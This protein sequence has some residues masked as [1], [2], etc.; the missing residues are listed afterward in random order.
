MRHNSD[1][2][3]AHWGRRI[4]IPLRIKVINP[5]AVLTVAIDPIYPPSSESDSEYGRE[6]CMVEQG[7]EL[8]EK[9]IEEIQREAAE[10][11][12][13]AKCLAREL[14]KKKGHNDMHDDSEASKDEH[15][16]RAPTRRHHPIFNSRR[17]TD[18]DQVRHRSRSICEEIGQ[19]EYQGEQVY[20]T[21][22]HNAL[23]SKMLVDQITPSPQR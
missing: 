14:D 2:D 20:R 12:A 8:P 3:L 1:T 9:T 22:A 17:N 11:I 4:Q 7:G 6:V 15:P 23:A 5:L 18:R 10:E 19:V 16:K 13:R 21:P